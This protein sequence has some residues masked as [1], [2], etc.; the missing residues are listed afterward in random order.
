MNE[1][2][3]LL[4]TVKVVTGTV[5]FAVNWLLQS[6][7]LITTGLLIG[8]MLRRCGSA[9]QSSVYRT[10]LV[11]VLLCPLATWGLSWAG[12]RGWSVTLPDSWTYEDV[13][14]ANVTIDLALGNGAVEPV[15][16]TDG[17]G[18]IVPALA[19]PEF[20]EV[21]TPGIP[22]TVVSAEMATGETSPIAED[23]ATHDVM[24]TPPSPI[25]TRALVVQPFGLL[26]FGCVAVWLFVS[27]GLLGRLSVAWW[28]LV[29]LR[30]SAV[31]VDEETMRLSRELAATLDVN[32]PD[33]QR[34]AYLP[35][36]CLAG[37]GR[38]TILLPDGDLVLS[39]RD[40]LVHELA[41]LKRRDCHWNLLRQSACA[42]LFFQPL[43][44]RLSQSL[45]RTAEEVCDDYVV[46]YGGDREDYANR[47]VD[48]AELATAPIARAGVGVVSL[49][50]MLARRV[51]R[52]MDTS[53]TLSTRVG[54]L[55]LVVVLAGGL[56]GTVIAGFV[57]LGGQPATADAHVV[58]DT[59]DRTVAKQ[60]DDGAD[61]DDDERD[62]AMTLRGTVVRPDGTPC[63]GARLFL[64]YGVP[65]AIGMLAADTDPV[66][67][68]NAQGEFHFVASP[69][70]SDSYETA[71]EF[72][73]AALVAVKDGFGFGWSHVAR[74]ETSGQ[75]LNDARER[76]ND[77]S[78]DLRERIWP[79]IAG[80]GGPIQLVADDQPIH[81][82]IVDFAGQPVVGARLTLLE[83]WTGA[84]GNLSEWRAATQEPE[85]DY[86]TAR[87]KTPRCIN[88]AQVRSLVSP[89]IT[90]DDGHFTLAGVG[91]G[92]I[93]V[94]II[95]GPSIATEKLFVRSEAGG[96]IEL[97]ES[98][99]T[100]GRGTHVYLP[101]ELNHVARPSIAITGMVRDA[102]TQA[103]LAG[104]TVTSQSRHGAKSSGWG[105]DFIRTV[106][107]DE[108]RFRLEGMPIGSDNSIAAIAPSGDIPYL[109]VRRRAATSADGDVP[110]I[111]FKLHRGVWIEGRVVD[112]PTG[113]GVRGTLTC[114]AKSENSHYANVRFGYVDQRSILRS[115]RDGRFRIA[116]LPGPGYIAFMADKDDYPRAKSILQLDGSRRRVGRTMLD[117]SPLDLISVNYHLIAEI[118]PDADTEGVELN[119]S[120]AGE[121]LAS[122]EGR[123]A[124]SDDVELAG[125]VVDPDGRPIAGAIV[126]RRV[127][128]GK[129]SDIKT[130]EAGRFEMDGIG[131]GTEEVHLVV[132]ADAY[133]T[134][135]GFS[136]QLEDDGR[137]EVEWTLQYGGVVEGRVMRAGDEESLGGVT[138]VAG[139]SRFANS[140]AI[141][142]TTTDLEG[143]Y[144]LTGV[145]PGEVYIHAFSDDFVPSMR[146]VN[147][148]VGQSARANFR[149]ETGESVTGRVVDAKGR[150]IEGAW[151]ITDEWNGI[152]MFAREAHTDSSGEFEL[153]HM[154]GP[155][156]SVDVL[157]KEHVA[158]RD[159]EVKPGDHHEI[160][161][162]RV[163]KH[164]VSVRLADKDQ[165]PRKLD[166]QRGYRWKAQ[167]AGD[168][169]WQS[170]S[171]AQQQY[172]SKTG[173]YT[174]SGSPRPDATTFWRFRAVVYKPEVIEVPDDATEPKKWALVLQPAERFAGRVVAA[175]TGQPLS[176]VKVLFIS[177]DAPLWMNRYGA[178][179]NRSRA[180]EQFSGLHTTSASDGSFS[181]DVPESGEDLGFVV[182]EPGGASFFIPNAAAWFVDESPEIPLPATTT[183]EGLIEEDGQRVPGETV[184]IQWIPPGYTGE[185][186]TLPHSL[187]SDVPY[188][189]GGEVKADDEG[190][191]RFDHLAPGRYAVSWVRS[192]DRPDGSRLSM[193]VRPE[194]VFVTSQASSIHNLVKRRDQVAPDVE[195]DSGPVVGQPVPELSAWTLEKGQRFRWSPGTNTDT[196]L[197]FGSLWH[198]RDRK[199]LQAARTWAATRDVTLVVM[200]T[201]WSLA[202]ARRERKRLA[203]DLPIDFAGC[204]GLAIA[205]AW[206]LR[207]DAQLY[208]IDAE[209][210]LKSRPEAGRLPED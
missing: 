128:G 188:A 181:L 34:S 45:E 43:L 178:F 209:G 16:S 162:S 37:L 30:R 47:L 206:G 62:V 58:T 24:S 140:L 131:A 59:D 116:A 80:A 83:V 50:W 78:V 161:L 13:E 35:S 142:T 7:L 32:A 135:G 136:Q 92:R 87:T 107:D 122:I 160:T 125:R 18:A 61:T 54:N 64:V 38:P 11:A 179:A 153:V 196:L 190:R 55:L 113:D 77:E 120:L 121:N 201:D 60:V 25:D 46:T 184:S 85:A 63:A 138:V 53:R 4:V 105:E 104:V 75:W 23:L 9:V 165:P 143:R 98:Q 168:M 133:V 207:G 192:V 68:T 108:G 19:E 149:L 48:V 129:V 56:L 137:T 170:V 111:D 141:P 193:H 203:L 10:T 1:S 182:I 198:P 148:R 132:A 6:T 175:D 70:G 88:A 76:L 172:D 99:R 106:T 147:A 187:R 8:Q 26:A 100:P 126:R 139:P 103:P 12:V 204:G 36:P 195:A 31:P 210:M 186:R 49:R 42:L 118:N 91:R 97:L 27:V 41:H 3:T 167:E 57:G 115:D 5:E 134:R 20:T 14:T 40:V 124:A 208:L 81:G 102:S 154:P 29:R 17:P 67:T 69:R 159:L 174:F 164:T 21:Q 157:K 73:Q 119:L 101:A 51:M 117:T 197:M 169:T 205:K 65:Q 96:A 183:L 163:I 155:K 71:W 171:F 109:S 33:V 84:N 93:A 144:R 89:A 202:Q 194:E 28:R 156:V 145:R 112:E 66:A 150:P 127:R 72:G 110:E 79:I 2:D 86:Y 177:N 22:D 130:D 52:I 82:D 176:N 94:L 44:W 191:Y 151:L 158:L 152:R 166:I 189:L 114:V 74:H 180:I 39:A 123:E 15:T 185:G 200:S 173:V 95:E 199:I 90:D 146:L